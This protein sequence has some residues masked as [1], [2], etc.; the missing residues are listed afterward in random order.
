[1]LTAMADMLQLFLG[2]ASD[3]LTEQVFLMSLS[4]VGQLR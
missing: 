2:A 1:M 4:V 3:G